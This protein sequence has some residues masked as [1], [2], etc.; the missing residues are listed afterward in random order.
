MGGDVESMSECG[1]W[2]PRKCVDCKGKHWMTRGGDIVGPRDVGR[3]ADEKVNGRFGDGTLGGGVACEC[4]Q[5][6][7]DSGDGSRMVV[8]I[9]GNGFVAGI[10][11][12]A[13]CLRKEVHIEKLGG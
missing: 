13:G 3:V 11:S 10:G 1:Y 9:D 4:M 8:A 2:V 6:V 5:R 7:L 12:N